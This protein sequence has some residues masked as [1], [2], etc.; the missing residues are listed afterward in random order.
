M[1]HRLLIYQQEPGSS[2][3]SSFR[4]LDV[5]SLRGRIVRWR[6]NKGGEYTWEEFR[7]YYLETGIVQEFN[8][9]NIPQQIDVSKRVGRTLYA[10]VQYM[11]ADS[12]FS[13]SMWGELFMKAA[14]LKNR[15]THKGLKMETQ[16][17]ML[18][19]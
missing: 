6:A 3:A 10:I 11:L 8:A 16:F 4:R 17:K 12:D 1:D 13:S 9:N 15:T 18:Q 2:A 19:G 5:H 14:Y 7:Q